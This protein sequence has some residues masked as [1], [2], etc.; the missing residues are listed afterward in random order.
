MSHNDQTTLNLRLQEYRH[1]ASLFV[2]YLNNEQHVELIDWDVD[3]D[4]NDRPSPVDAETVL[5]QFESY[6]RRKY[7]ALPEYAHLR[8]QS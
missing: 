4:G 6:M 5:N 1:V 2:H 3:P 7:L 8:D